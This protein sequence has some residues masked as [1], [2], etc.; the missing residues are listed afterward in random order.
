MD[1]R[2]GRLFPHGDLTEDQRANSRLNIDEWGMQSR[3]LNSVP[4]RVVLELTNG[5]NL[6]CAMCGRNFASFVPTEFDFSWLERFGDVFPKAEEVTL[7]GWG[8]PTIYSRFADV[9]E[10]LDQFPVRKYI[11]TN[12]TKLKELTGLILDR[13]VDI[14]AVSIDG[15]SP[16]V[17]DGIRIGASLDAVIR[18]IKSVQEE[19]VRRSVA[20]PYMRIVFTAM[21][22]NLRELPDLVSLAADVGVSEVKVVNFTVFGE[23]M[24]AECLWDDMERVG[25]VFNA[26][27]EVGIAS[28]VK[29]SLPALTGE[30]PAGD[31]PHRP[32]DLGWR[33]FFVGSDGYVRPCM[34]TSQKLFHIDT[35]G[36][37]EEMWNSPELQVFR[38]SVNDDDRMPLNCRLCY[39][40]SYANWNQEHAFIQAGG[41]FAPDWTCP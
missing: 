24:L 25:E 14:V 38:A 5:C 13:H 19:A 31:A 10:Y 35:Y 40:A 39:Q 29:L 9:L 3:V 27:R 18:G 32:C 28:G 34:S 30:D 4:R 22:S 12:G 36:S 2:Q 26:A 1:S 33:D 41:T 8:E 21:R 7:M 17:N 37:F 16:A 23:D 20:G 11:C 15:A 6:R